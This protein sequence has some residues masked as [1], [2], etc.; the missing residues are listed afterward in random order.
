MVLEECLD[1]ARAAL[2]AG[3]RSRALSELRRGYAI[4]PDDPRLIELFR[5]ATQD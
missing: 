3:D 2:A 4:K 1:N 5:K